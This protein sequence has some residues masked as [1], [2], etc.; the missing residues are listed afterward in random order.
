M[1]KSGNEGSG[2][3]G[4]GKR[5]VVQA[6]DKLTAFLELDGVICTSGELL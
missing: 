5:F 6:D 3:N 1:L 2:R 4:E